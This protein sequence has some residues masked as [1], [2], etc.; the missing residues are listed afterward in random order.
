MTAFQRALS[1]GLPALVVTATVA[2]QLRGQVA[3]EAPAPAAARQTA[4]V[5]D[6]LLR[7]FDFTFNKPAPLDEVAAQLSRQ[8]NLPVALDLAAI[9]RMGLKPDDEVRLDLRGVRL[10]TGLKLLLDQL[11]LTYRVVPEDN[12]LIFTDEEG[13]ED[14]VDRVLTE[15]KSLH[16][17]VHDLQD[18]VD[19][20]RAA[21]G[22]DEEGG[23]R[24]RKPTIIEEVPADEAE[25]PRPKEAAPGA[26]APRSR[27]GV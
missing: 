24:M 25:R 26:A 3:S 9:D 5:Q 4:S 22:V 2:W 17:D 12:L 1:V 15:V 6:A 11:D 10:K 13:S 8:L 21:L 16:R 23:P 20:L 27:P 18:A 19:E 7:P 14:P